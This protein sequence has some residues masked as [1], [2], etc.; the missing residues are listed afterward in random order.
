MFS[1]VIR[2]GAF[3]SLSHPGERVLGYATSMKIKTL[4]TDTNAKRTKEGL[5][6]L[7]LNNSLDSAAQTKAKN[8][9]QLDYWSHN[10][11]SGKPPW[12]FVA[13]QNYSYQVLGENLAAGFTN[14][15]AVVNAWMASAEHRANILNPDFSQVGFGVAQSPDYRSAGGGPMTIVVAYYAKPAPAVS[16][17]VSH[18][19]FFANSPTTGAVETSH[20]QLALAGVKLASAGTILA[21]G[22]ITTALGIMVGR[23]LIAFRR[24]LRRGE[25]F[26]A[27]HPLVDVGFLAIVF[28]A[29]ILTQTAGL[30][31]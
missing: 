19:R 30:I 14:E 29:Y 26:V 18:P 13:S 28:L 4:F 12:I 5:P 31:K 7:A 10:T 9:A 27:K 1:L 21:V 24:A 17:A 15:N 20:A 23:H 22:V 6:A 8:M 16:F 3:S 2:G 11:P 25:K